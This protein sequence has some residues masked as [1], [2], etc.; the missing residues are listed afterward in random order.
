VR[1]WTLEPM[2][3]DSRKKDAGGRVTVGDGFYVH[4]S[5]IYVN[6]CKYKINTYYYNGYTLHSA[7]IPNFRVFKTLHG[8]WRQK[9]G[10]FGLTLTLHSQGILLSAQGQVLKATLDNCRELQPF[11]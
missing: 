8:N 2:R 11:P 4:G 5:M 3:T 9:S 1:L 10:N 7:K 6:N